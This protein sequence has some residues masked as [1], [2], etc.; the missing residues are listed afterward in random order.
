MDILVSISGAQPYSAGRIL[1]GLSIATSTGYQVGADIV[2]DFAAST[3]QMNASVR[4]K[5][6]EILVG[7]GVPATTS[8]RIRIAG[9][10]V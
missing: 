6:I 4:T 1:A 10:F 8:D 9:G 7:Q 2:V 5:A 3:T